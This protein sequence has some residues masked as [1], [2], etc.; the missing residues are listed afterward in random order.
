MSFVIRRQLS[1]LIPPK[2]ASAKVC[3]RWIFCRGWFPR[4]F[5]VQSGES[6]KRE[7]RLVCL[8]KRTRYVCAG[9]IYIWFSS[10][11][12]VL[13]IF[14]WKCQARDF[15]GFHVF[16]VCSVVLCSEFSEF[17]GKVQLLFSELQ[18]KWSRTLWKWIFLKSVELTQT[19]YVIRGTCILRFVFHGASLSHHPP[20]NCGYLYELFCDFLLWISFALSQ[21]LQLYYFRGVTINLHQPSSTFIFTLTEKHAK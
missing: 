12:I 15:C 2:I 13:L 21:K 16:R 20:C 5:L 10:S 7:H 19:W 3:T 1:T 6:L 11:V 18:E 14:C 17:F 4:L 9:K 8:K